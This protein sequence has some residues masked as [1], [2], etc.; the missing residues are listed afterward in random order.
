[1]QSQ[2]VLGN[3]SLLLQAGDTAKTARFA[4]VGNCS[5]HFSTSGRILSHMIEEIIF[6]NQ[7]N[8]SPYRKRCSPGIG[9][10][11]SGIGNLARHEVLRDRLRMRSFKDPRRAK[12][13]EFP[14]KA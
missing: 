11:M 9:R 7:E 13:P 8:T 10:E 3:P 4:G 6:N 5:P 14:Y 2:P 1:M 12:L